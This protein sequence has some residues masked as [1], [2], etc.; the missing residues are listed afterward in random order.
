MKE[1]QQQ[2]LSFA[3]LTA[4]DSRPP[5]VSRPDPAAL[6]AAGVSTG[7]GRLRKQSTC[8]SSLWN[9]AEANG[10]CKLQTKTEARAAYKPPP[11]GTTRQ[12]PVKPP[13]SQIPQANYPTVLQ[14]VTRAD[15]QPDVLQRAGPP[16]RGSR[17]QDSGNPLQGAAVTAPDFNTQT[18]CTFKA[19]STEQWRAANSKPAGCPATHLVSY[20]IIHGGPVPAANPCEAFVAGHDYRRTR[21]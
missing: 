15:Y 8:S 1:P 16:C 6:P 4:A 12:V 20:N 17:L 21:P 11:A 3:D 18:A 2:G 14:S 5:Q 7:C 10:S 9:T 19:H 13:G